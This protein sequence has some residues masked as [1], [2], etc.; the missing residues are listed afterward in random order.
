MSA[1]IA[2]HLVR[3]K[4]G[5]YMDE[6]D[7]WKDDHEQ[8]MLYFDFCDLVIDGIK[9]FRDICRLDEQWRSDVFQKKIE[10]DND[11]DEKISSLF[12]QLAK[13]S[14]RVESDM[15][16]QAEADFGEVNKADEFRSV[17]ESLRGIITPDDEFFQHEKLLD[18]QK[19]AILEDEQGKTVE[20]D[21][22]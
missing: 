13:I 7:L 16:P 12:W 11:F 19:Q 4:L 14:L 21:L 18:L 17:C 22:N 5:T 8:A 6:Y 20:Y 9:L 3:D 2:E 15:L 10:Y 1:L